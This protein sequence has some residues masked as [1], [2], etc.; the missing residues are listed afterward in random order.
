MNGKYEGRV[1]DSANYLSNPEDAAAYLT[2]AIEE[3]GDDPQFIAHAL[4][5]VARAGNLSELSRNTGISRKGIYKAFSQTGNPSFATVV[6]VASSLGLKLK[7]DV[8]E[9]HA[10][11]A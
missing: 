8:S 7:F 6:K 2:A 1:F 11:P 10:Q 9:T 3:A 5:V 4:G